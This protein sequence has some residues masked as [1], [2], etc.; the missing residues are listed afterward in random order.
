ML[1]ADV[2]E[3]GAGSVAGRRR[4]RSRG[5]RGS[6]SRP[7]AQAGRNVGR[8]GR[9][10]ARRVLRPR[11]GL[12]L[13]QLRLGDGSSLGLQL[14]LL[15][16]NY[17][18]GGPLLLLAQEQGRVGIDQKLRGPLAG[19]QGALADAGGAQELAQVKRGVLAKQVGNVLRWKKDHCWS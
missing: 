19:N 8:R 6:G 5:R 18:R 4:A 2:A 17:E 3:P 7:I 11:V 12:Q 10:Q 1:L 15:L 14:L 16:L 9:G 13:R